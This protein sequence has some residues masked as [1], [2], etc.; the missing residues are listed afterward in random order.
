M[1]SEKPGRSTSVVEV[2][3]ISEHGFWLLLSTGEPF[4][5]F[6]A[7]PSFRDATIA[8]LQDV[9]L[10]HREHLYWPE[11]DVDLALESI[12]HPE[13]YPLISHRGSNKPL[14]QSVGAGKVSE[15][16]TPKRRAA[17]R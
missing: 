17:H 2:T 14:Q 8:Q 10:L 9:R 4:V 5:S 1:K 7:F 15:R 3:H 12:F 6:A 11:L 16:P 13:R